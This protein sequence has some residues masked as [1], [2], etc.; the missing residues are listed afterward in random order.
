MKTDEKDVIQILS[1]IDDKLIEEANPYG[2]GAAGADQ[3][4]KAAY[5][6]GSK[7]AGKAARGKWLRPAMG[8]AAAAAVLVIGFALIKLG[9][10]AMKPGSGDR[11]G[12][13][14]P[15]PKIEVTAT[16]TVG[17]EPTAV[18]TA[19]PTEA[20]TPTPTEAAVTST[21]TPTE[22]ATPTPTEAA[23]PTP[24][25][26]AKTPT[27]KPTKPAST[28]TPTP[29]PA[30][31]AYTPTPTP[32]PRIPESTPT[33]KIPESTPTPGFPVFTPTPTMGQ[34]PTPTPDPDAGEPL[35]YAAWNSLT[36]GEHRIRMSDIRNRDFYK[37]LSP[38]L[39][40]EY[41]FNS[42]TRR[43]TE[44][45]KYEAV[46]FIKKDED[47]YKNFIGI[48]VRKKEDTENY[49]ERLVSAADVEV[50][51]VDGREDPF[52]VVG[53]EFYNATNSPIFQPEEFTDE[54]LARRVV[55][56]D[57][58]GEQYEQ[59]WFAVDMGDDYV[60]HY[61]FRGRYE[62]VSAKLFVSDGVLDEQTVREIDDRQ[63]QK[64]P[65][66]ENPSEKTEEAVTSA[67][68]YTL[69]NLRGIYY[70]DAVNML[71]EELEK[72]GITN[73]TVYY[74]WDPSNYDPEMNAKIMGSYPVPG[75]VITNDGEYTYIELFA[76][77]AAPEWVTR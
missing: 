73:V 39:L 57:E 49:E 6:G 5:V 55:H 21:P 35:P 69:P 50:Y 72:A 47:D 32:T 52:T 64:V 19:D 28:P 24:T 11:P 4:N 41:S 3:V 65:P 53:D 68:T 62:N 25:E 76:A 61:V 38:D 15:T 34:R 56:Y 13:S 46:W 9:V 22:A 14:T 44:Y 16:P 29:T 7:A 10:P 30:E 36:T 71:K 26:A 43:D 75:T 58:D 2:A 40:S 27:P 31:P 60:F 42:A 59:L 54:V 51:D 63:Y 17:T 20:V 66:S 45:D 48:I 18:P 23:T 12:A 67:P 8:I 77:E 70:A 1:G 37:Y 33:P 74:C